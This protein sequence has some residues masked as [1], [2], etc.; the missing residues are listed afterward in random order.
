MKDANDYKE[1][2]IRREVGEQKEGEEEKKDEE[3]EGEE[4]KEVEKHKTEE[5]K[6][7]RVG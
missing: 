5:G 2:K 3:K 1:R 4:E 7:K 6:E